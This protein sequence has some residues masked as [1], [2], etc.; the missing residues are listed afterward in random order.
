MSNFL[1]Y[2][3]IVNFEYFPQTDSHFA[4]I[5]FKHVFA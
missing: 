5:G 1:T 2:Q 3:F 4:I